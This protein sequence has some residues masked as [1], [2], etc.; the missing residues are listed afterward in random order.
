LPLLVA[1]YPEAKRLVD[2]CAVGLVFDPKDPAS[3]AA[4][5]NGLAENAELAARCR[6]A[7]PR[8]LKAMNVD[9]EWTRLVDIY[10]RLQGRGTVPAPAGQMQ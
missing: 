9:E 8:A 2:E 7:I 3:I 4:A 10:D 6:A 1:H 5:M